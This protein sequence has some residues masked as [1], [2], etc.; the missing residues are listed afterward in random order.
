MCRL[1]LIILL[2]LLLCCYFLLH[3]VD[4]IPY[5]NQT[6]IL[7]QLPSSLE[8]LPP[9]SGPLPCQ[10]L[11]PKSLPGFTYMA[12]LPKYLVGLSLMIALKE[13]GCHADVQALQ[14]Q[15]YRQ[16]GIYATQT[17]T[18]YLQGLE[19]GRNTERGVSV[20][21]LASALQLLA[22]E[23]LGPER[24]RR[25]LTIKDCEYKQEQGV[26]DVVK[27]LPG[28]GTYYNLGTALYYATQNCL[29]KAK[30]RGKDGVMDL[31]YDLLINAAGLSGGPMGLVITA[32]LKPAVKAGVE[33][34]IQYYREKEE[35]T[36]P[37]ETSE[38]GLGSTSNVGDMV[39]T[40]TVAPLVSE[41]V[42]SAPYWGWS[43]FKN[44]YLDP[45]NW[46]FGI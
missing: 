18:Q 8:F 1:R 21:A 6:N 31:G 41:E 40:T 26:H 28:V 4:A 19:K 24:A 30:E 9:T 5:G 35:S 42:N 16:G 15:L 27:L 37:P 34:L 39:E 11:L 2:E 23:Q 38:E 22:R 46:S 20:D 29:D 33:R 43:S 45:R 10:T 32:A 36:P 7:M 14:L 17:L 44:Y 13:A 3:P 12:P 25:S